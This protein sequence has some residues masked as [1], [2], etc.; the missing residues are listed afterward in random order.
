MK[1]PCAKCKNKN[2][3]SICGKCIHRN[4]VYFIQADEV[5]DRA[6]GL[7]GS[8][9]RYHHPESCRFGGFMDECKNQS[10]C[11]HKRANSSISGK[12]STYDRI[13]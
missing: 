7:V 6:D 9:C 8:A 12:L 2:G 3:A 11:E 13:K 10:E 5:S 1:R 4:Y